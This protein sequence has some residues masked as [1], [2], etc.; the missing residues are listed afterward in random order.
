MGPRASLDEVQKRE[1]FILPGL[2]LRHI[3]RLAR[4]QLLYRLSYPDSQQKR[5][6]MNKIHRGIG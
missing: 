5:G 2:E 1:F 3:R 4:N 6:S